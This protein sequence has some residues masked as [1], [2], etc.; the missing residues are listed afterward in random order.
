ME[1]GTRAAIIS[2]FS[3][4]SNYELYDHFRTV[5]LSRDYTF[6]YAIINGLHS[7]ARYRRYVRSA[8]GYIV[9]D[10]DVGTRDKRCAFIIQFAATDGHISTLGLHNEKLKFLNMIGVHKGI[11]V[12]N[13]PEDHSARPGLLQEFSSCEASHPAV[14]SQG[15]GHRMMPLPQP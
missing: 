8:R 4:L 1:Q 3:R 5:S 10:V 15:Q 12:C 13:D 11:H 14:P 7:A 2:G 6:L 9:L